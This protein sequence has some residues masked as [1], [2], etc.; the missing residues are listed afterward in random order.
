MTAS[1]FSA[2]KTQIL[3]FITIHMTEFATT[4]EVT[5][6]THLIL[7]LWVHMQKDQAQSTNQSFLM[8]EVKEAI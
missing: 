5:N 2:S 1:I 6:R 8:M 3:F 7:E 4:Y